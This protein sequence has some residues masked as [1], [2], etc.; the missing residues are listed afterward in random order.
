MRSFT[1]FML[2]E[3]VLTLGTTGDARALLKTGV[4]KSMEDVRT[5]AMSSTE[6]SKILAFETAQTYVWGTE[7]TR[8]VNKVLADYDAAATNDAKLNIIATEY[9]LAAHGNGIEMYNLYRRTGMPNNQQPG[10]TPTPGGF[11]RSYYYPLAFI[12]RN[13][14]VKQKENATKPVFWDTNPATLTK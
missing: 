10:L 8:Y 4:E 13:S 1:D 12:G 2:A 7:A 14:N 6:A 3:A 9:W 5:F 11:V